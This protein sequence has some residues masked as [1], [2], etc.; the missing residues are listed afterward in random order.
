MLLKWAASDLAADLAI[1]GRGA[2]VRL[3]GG[4]APRLKAF[5]IAPPELRTGD[6]IVASDFYAG[7]FAFSG[8]IALTDGASPF[9]IQPPSLAWAE[10]LCGFGWLR[11]L[12]AARS[13]LARDN[14]RQLLMD[15]VTGRH[16]LQPEARSAHVTARRLLSLLTHS[17]LLLDGAE[18]ETYSA[19]LDAVRADTERLLV[20]RGGRLAPDTLLLSL[21]ALVMVGLCVD[22][23]ERLQRRQGEELALELD[24][25]VL[26]DGG[27]I[28]RNPRVL[29]DLLLDLLP[30]RAAY[31]ARGIDPPAGLLAALDRI[32]P[33]LKL[34]RHPDGGLAVFNGMG[35]SRLDALATIFASHDTTGRAATSAPF[36]GYHRVEGERAVLIVDTGPPPLPSASLE[37]H[38]SC[39][40]FEFSAGRQRLMVSCG[41]PINGGPRLPVALRSTAAHTAV[42]VDDSSSGRF[43]ERNGLARLY[44]G[45]TEVN[46]ATATLPEGERIEISHDGYA[47]RF[48]LRLRRTLT[49]AGDGATL[50]GDDT[51]ER[52]EGASLPPAAARFHL[53]PLVRATALDEGGIRLEPPGGPAWLFRAGDAPVLLEDSICYIGAEGARRTQQIVVPFGGEQP[54]ISWRL[55]RL[56]PQ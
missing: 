32:V 49:L 7:Q 16:R 25:Q 40:A 31:V 12:Q 5:I 20:L 15:F 26:A 4:G 3:P 54:A 47:Q 6:P 50:A 44:P 17:P 22:G 34:L 51:L 9:L 10:A 30:L 28:S 19:C 2:L 23:A 36:T 48:G 53:H 33:H 35:D 21:I 46:V 14:A 41:V 27:H 37:A 55:T 56:P 45:A 29:V 38:A 11:H 39:G 8:K 18:H 1:A 24:E 42:V 52:D 43:I 13:T